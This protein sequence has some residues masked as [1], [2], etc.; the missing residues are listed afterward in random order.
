[1]FAIADAIVFRPPGTPAAAG[2]TLDFTDDPSM[3]RV[4]RQRERIA[5]STSALALPP[6]KYRAN[7]VIQGITLQG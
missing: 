5:G 4:S 2:T 6:E 7:I 3:A 1:M